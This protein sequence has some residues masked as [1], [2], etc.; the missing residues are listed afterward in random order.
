MS[1]KV[2]HKMVYDNRDVPIEPAGWRVAV[3]TDDFKGLLA[4]PLELGSER[5][6]MRA[7]AALEKA[8]LE[9]ITAVKRAG[10]GAVFRIML[11]ALAW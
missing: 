9:S 4:I 6:A 7:K 11:E 5:D 2:T 1:L 3:W 8:G 10:K